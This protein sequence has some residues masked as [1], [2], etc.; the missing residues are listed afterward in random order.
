VR[1]PDDPAGQD[2][3]NPLYPD[4]AQDFVHSFEVLAALPCEVFLAEHGS[5]YDLLGKLARLRAAKPGDPD[6]FIDPQ[7]CRD[8]VTRSRATFAAQLQAEQAATPAQPQGR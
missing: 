6:P 5:S 8:F 4:A 7:G 2:H 1:L 3:G